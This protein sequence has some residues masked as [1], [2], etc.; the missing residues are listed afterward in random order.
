MSPNPLLRGL[1]AVHPGALLRDTI[2]PAVG[3]SRDEIAWAL[4]V[5]RAALDDV[6]DERQPITPDVAARLGGLFGNSSAFWLGMQQSHD[7]G[8]R[9][10]SLAR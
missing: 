1:P 5:A 4:G 9:S 3:K 6:L 10:G 7:F 2:L 8:R